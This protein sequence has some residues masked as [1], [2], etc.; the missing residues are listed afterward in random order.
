MHGGQIPVRT[1][2]F[3]IFEV[4]RE[5]ELRWDLIAESAWSATPRVG[6]AMTRDPMDGLLS[7]RVAADRRSLAESPRHAVHDPVEKLWTACG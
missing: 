5:V 3:V 6:E 4:V 7:G 1:W 2:V